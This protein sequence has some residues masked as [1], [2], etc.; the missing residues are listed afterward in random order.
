MQRPLKHG[1]RQGE[2]VDIS[3]L[4]ELRKALCSDMQKRMDKIESKLFW[5]NTV[6]I[7]NLIAFIIVLIKEKVGL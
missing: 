6:A 7:G 2:V 3:E 1:D 4:E 5:F